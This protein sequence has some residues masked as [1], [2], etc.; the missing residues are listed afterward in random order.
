MSKKPSKSK[1]K[2][3]AV[4]PARKPQAGQLS[5]PLGLPR[6]L[7]RIDRMATASGIIAGKPETFPPGIAMAA[8]GW[9]VFNLVMRK[10][11]PH[12]GR[13]I[14]KELRWHHDQQARQEAEAARLARRPAAMQH[15]SYRL[16]EA[17][18]G[19]L[20]KRLPVEIESGAEWAVHDAIGWP[21]DPRVHRAVHDAIADA[22]D[23]AYRCGCIEGF[24]EGFVERRMPD[25]K[26]SDTGNAAKR[27]TLVQLPDGR[28]MTRDDRD[29]LMVAEYESLLALKVKPTPAMERLAEK[30][31][32]ESWQG[33]AAAMKSFGKRSGR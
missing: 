15:P 5:L 27:K 4:R 33:V 23:A 26:R 9:P 29:A 11:H 7:P 28:R 10:P 30:Y 20:R 24:I 22:C 8:S 3:V 19:W 2:R 32:F 16:P 18:Q 21:D 1:A 17:L 12:A 14:Q 31:G 13:A 6:K 25:K